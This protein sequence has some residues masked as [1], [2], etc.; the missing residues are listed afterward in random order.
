MTHPSQFKFPPHTTHLWVELHP[1]QSAPITGGWWA[2][3]TAPGAGSP[4]T[5]TIAPTH[6]IPD[7]NYGYYGHSPQP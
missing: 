6:P 1:E 2:Y 7:Y 4:V 5:R 3:H